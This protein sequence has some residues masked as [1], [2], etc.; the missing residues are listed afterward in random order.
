MED[1]VLT[2]RCARPQ[3]WLIRTMRDLTGLGLA[4]VTRQL[5]EGTCRWH[6]LLL[7]NDHDELAAAVRSLLGRAGPE[8]EIQVHEL[9]PDGEVAEA[10]TPELLLASLDAWDELDQPDG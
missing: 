7:H 1:V 9:G 8:V 10:A 6:I 3:P 5:R 4:L 2:L